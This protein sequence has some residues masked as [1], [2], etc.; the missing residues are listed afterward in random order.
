MTSPTHI[1]MPVWAAAT[2]ALALILPATAAGQNTNALNVYRD[3]NY[4]AA[5]PLLQAAISKEP[6]NPMLR[7]A[8]LSALVYE[9]KVDEASDAAESDAKRFLNS[10]D[11][12]AARGEFAYY[13]GDMAE[14]DALFRAALKRNP[15]T[16]RA[17]YGL[18][19]LYHAAS[20]YRSARL[21]CMKA[22]EMDPGDALITHLWMSYLVGEKRKELLF[23]FIATHPWFYKDN[24]KNRANRADINRELHGRKEFQ[25]VGDPHET[26]LH[27]IRI[28]RDPTHIEGVGLGFRMDGGHRL[29]LLLDTGA[30][31][32]LLPQRSI[33]K[34]GLSHL[35][36]MD[37][38]GIGDDGKEKAFAA[39]ADTC[40][41]GGLQFHT[42][43]IQ[44][45]AGNRH[46]PGDSDGIIGADVFSD[47]LEELN[48]QKLSLRLVPLPPRPASP[49]Q[50]DRVI[51]SGDEDFTPVFRYGDHFFLST[52]LNGKITG[53][54]LIDTGAALSSV[55][56]TFARL[57]VKLQDSQWRI[58]GI[59]GAVKHVFE[60]DKAV[61]VFARYSQSNLGLTSFD[62]NNQPD[63]QEVRMSGILGFPVLSLFRITL[64]YRNGLV[65][66]DYIYGK[67][68][69]N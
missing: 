59:S 45:L 31:G 58:K 38:W 40:R 1:F 50:Y 51:G 2:A 10:P 15:D 17:V 14:A 37:I 56:S 39:I 47:Y 32:I 67:H 46:V 27:L 3:G 66:F 19:R 5:I 18:S 9:G 22:H 63:H 43:L 8:L 57:S 52:Q 12:I 54:F 62:M 25:L 48:F 36:L 49:Q 41:I 7:A 28:M 30:S 13:M 29:Q 21:L 33:N 35:G 64:D 60:I 44:A 34:A 6:D 69:R 11:V 24:A 42:C 4:K 26:T 16:A 68:K 53:L 61:L 23:P 20:L 55:D 65:K